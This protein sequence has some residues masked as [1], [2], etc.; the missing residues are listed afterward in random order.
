MACR[1]HIR[2]SLANAKIDSQILFDIDPEWKGGVCIYR[3]G[4]AGVKGYNDSR[5]D[6]SSEEQIAV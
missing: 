3:R 2:A 6:K 5:R 4:W 1:R